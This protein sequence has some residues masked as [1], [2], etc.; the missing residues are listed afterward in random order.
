MRMVLASLREL[1]GSAVCSDSPARVLH[2][3]IGRARRQLTVVEDL[4]DAGM[5]DEIGGASLK[6]ASRQLGLHRK[7]SPQNFDR[8]AAANVFAQAFV[9]DAHPAFANLAMMR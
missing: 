1:R 8:G 7:L 2:R 9:D 4:H 3:Q 5:F 6:K